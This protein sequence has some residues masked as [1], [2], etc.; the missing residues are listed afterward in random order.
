MDSDINDLVQK[1]DFASIPEQKE[2]NN[3]EISRNRRSSRLRHGSTSQ[4][5]VDSDSD[6][7]IDP[8]QLVTRNEK[9]ETGESFTYLEEKLSIPKIEI[10]RSASQRLRESVTKG[11]QDVMRDVCKDDDVK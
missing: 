1:M 5:N 2:P 11:E 3:S 9:S 6:S 10:N 8:K 4:G 7:T